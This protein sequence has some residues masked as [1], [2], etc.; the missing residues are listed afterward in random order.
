MFKVGRVLQFYTKTN[1]AV[2]E[3][4]GTLSVHD[5]V[6][7]VRNGETIFD[8]TVEVIQIEYRKVDSANR[9]DVI[10]LKTNEEAK[11]GD[12]IYKA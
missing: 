11:E 4:D 1:V 5:R 7:F 9:G 8:E 2:V 12:E 6:R 10:A 3:L